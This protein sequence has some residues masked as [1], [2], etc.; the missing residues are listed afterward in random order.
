MN[1]CLKVLKERI[2]LAFLASWA[3]LG[4]LLLLS[5]TLLVGFA[6]KK[7]TAALSSLSRP[8]SFLAATPGRVAWRPAALSSL[9]HA[10]SLSVSRPSSFL[11][12]SSSSGASP[13]DKG[14]PAPFP[15]LPFLLCEIEHPNPNY[16]ICIRI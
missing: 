13:A 2:R 12:S 11:A 1:Y 10:F 3:V 15:S 8:S 6:Q 4:L 5:F 7:R 9:S 14:M 16:A